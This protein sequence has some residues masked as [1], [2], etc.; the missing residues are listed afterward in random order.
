MSLESAPQPHTTQGSVY[1]SKTPLHAGNS[2]CRPGPLRN[3]Q[4]LV[5]FATGS[6]A[7]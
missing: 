3:W 1:C 6:S 7:R 4:S 5:G 2:S